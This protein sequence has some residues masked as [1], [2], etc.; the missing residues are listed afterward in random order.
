MKK[1][2]F[3]LFIWVWKCMIS[4]KWVYGLSD[5]SFSPKKTV[6]ERGKF[7]MKILH[8]IWNLDPTNIHI[9]P[10][11]VMQEF[12]LN[13]FEILPKNI[14]EPGIL[15]L[16]L[17]QKLFEI[18]FYGN[19]VWSEKSIKHFMSRLLYSILKFLTLF[20]PQSKD[21]IL[22]SQ[23]FSPKNLPNNNTFFHSHS[24]PFGSINIQLIF[25]FF[26][27]SVQSKYKNLPRYM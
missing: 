16:D 2:I 7:D 20:H 10:I 21:L 8:T 14:Q 27:V 12:D 22:N 25:S 5:S 1:K 24:N 15:F 3:F 9:S 26:P 4:W 17:L 23:P 11:I 6:F 19:F 18:S 13:L